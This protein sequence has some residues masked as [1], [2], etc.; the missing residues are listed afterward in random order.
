ML[1]GE[2]I[3]SK[4]SKNVL[5]R[6][7]EKQ[8]SANIHES[9]VSRSEALSKKVELPIVPL[10]RFGKATELQS[11][12]Q[13]SMGYSDDEL[14]ANASKGKLVP[15]DIKTEN[16]LD[17]LRNKEG[18]TI[19]MLPT[20]PVT[21]SSVAATNENASPSLSSGAISVTPP[22]LALHPHS[23]LDERSALEGAGSSMSLS[24]GINFSSSAAPSSPASYKT[25]TSSMRP[26]SHPSATFSIS[27]R[28]PSP[29]YSNPNSV[30]SSQDVVLSEPGCGSGRPSVDSP[31]I[32][33][34]YSDIGA[35]SEGN[36]ASD[37]VSQTSSVDQDFKEEIV[38]STKSE[39][40]N[41]PTT[42][43]DGHI[44]RDLGL[45]VPVSEIDPSILPKTFNKVKISTALP[46]SCRGAGQNPSSI[47][48]TL[49]N[50]MRPPK[51]TV[52]LERSQ[53]ICRTAI[54]KSPNWVQVDSNIVGATLQQMGPGSGTSKIIQNVTPSTIPSGATPVSS[55]IINPSTAGNVL[56]SVA[57]SGLS[58]T[59]ANPGNVIPITIRPPTTNGS[60]SV[61]IMAMGPSTM[62][63]TT[64]ISGIRATPISTTQAAGAMGNAVLVNAISNKVKFQICIRNMLS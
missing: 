39:T 5:L 43:T 49:I 54:A 8:S 55:M 56:P 45:K 34:T 3:S 27:S 20:I 1:L 2:H 51:G 16:S 17:T 12:S 33:A 46:I 19:S 36:D 53:E 15:T 6:R 7:K 52:N 4:G 22:L 57:V 31:A 48:T 35:P 32:S 26:T 40:T 9:L 64:P 13:V 61:Q 30:T 47:S 42:H 10:P 38:P 60:G 37:G 58:T 18:I 62:N 25:T 59:R 14:G 29:A 11:S 44:A 23:L 41:V 50:K 24:S 28:S 21:L 63:P